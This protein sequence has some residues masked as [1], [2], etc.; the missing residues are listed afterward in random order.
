MLVLYICQQSPSS[1]SIAFSV[2][3]VDVQE[4]TFCENLDNCVNKKL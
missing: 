4:R 1:S 2:F 3:G